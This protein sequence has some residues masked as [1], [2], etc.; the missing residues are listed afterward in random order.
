MEVG[1]RVLVLSQV[2]ASERGCARS[3]DREF[4]IALYLTGR[5]YTSSIVYIVIKEIRQP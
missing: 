4:T 3:H 2:D 5:G 1:V